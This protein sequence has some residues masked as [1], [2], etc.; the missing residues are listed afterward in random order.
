MRKKIF[1]IMGIV[2]VIALFTMTAQVGATPITFSGSGT[3][4]ITGQAISASATFDIVGTFLQVTLTN[5]GADV[6][7]PSDVLTAL[8]FNITGNPSLTPGSATLASGSS[9]LFGGSDPGGVVGGEWAY[10][11]IASGAPNGATQGISS[12]GLGIFGGAN[13]PGSNL[14]DPSAV[15]G[16]Q[17][18]IT[19]GA[20]NPSTGNAAVTGSNALIKNSVVFLLSNLQGTSLNQISNVS[21]Q[22]GT[23]LS[24]PNLPSNPVPEPTT[25]L[26]LGSGLI[27]M[28]GYGRKKFRKQLPA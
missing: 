8:F 12:S 6:M 1:T 19:S 3:N 5:T 7:A 9:V 25:L 17:Y 13:F 11:N 2:A 14:Q 15:D 4:P 21:F 24:E 16:V 27:G 22:Y 23:G 10:T 20:D 18:G 26:L 28:A